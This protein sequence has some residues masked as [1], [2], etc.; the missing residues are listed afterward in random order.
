MAYGNFTLKDL[1]KRFQLHEKIIALFNELEPVELGSWLIQTLD[2]GL[3]L[4]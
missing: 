2:L 4:A 3:P 1:L